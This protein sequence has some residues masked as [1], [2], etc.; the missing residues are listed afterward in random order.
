MSDRVSVVLKVGE[1]NKSNGVFAVSPVSSDIVG[2]A[3]EPVW[4]GPGRSLVHIGSKG[5]DLIPGLS[6]GVV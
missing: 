3:L 2:V 6:A 5:I 1:D 4:Q